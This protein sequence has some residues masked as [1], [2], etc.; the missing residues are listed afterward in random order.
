LSV[1]WKCACARAGRE[2]VCGCAGVCEV[3]FSCVCAVCMLWCV[4]S[5]RVCASVFEVLECVAVG[6]CVH[7]RVRGLVLGVSRCLR[8]DVLVCMC[9]VHGV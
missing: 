1:R 2:Q 5:L 6:A 9:G 4:K 8:G 7:E 3:I